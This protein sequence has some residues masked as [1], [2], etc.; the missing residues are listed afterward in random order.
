MVFHL[1]SAFLHSS[2]KEN[3]TEKHGWCAMG[4]GAVTFSESGTYG[5]RK[6]PRSSAILSDPKKEDAGFFRRCGRFGFLIGCAGVYFDRQG[7][8]LYPESPMA[9]DGDEGAS[10]PMRHPFAKRGAAELWKM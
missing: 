6:S 5:E 1:P 2:I 8:I 7:G 9:N 3:R 4:E 10:D